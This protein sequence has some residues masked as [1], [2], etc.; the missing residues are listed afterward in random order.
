MKKIYF[1]LSTFFALPSFLLGQEIPQTQK[2]VITKIAA[3]WCP[4]CG[5]QAWDNFEAL[6]EDYGDEA[7]F[8]N[9]HPSRSS[10]LHSPNAADFS[11]NL[12]EA[13]GQPL[14]YINR[15]KYITSAILSN[16]EEA[17]QTSKELEPLANTGVTATIKNNEIEARAKVQFFQEGEGSFLLSLLLIED[18]IIANQSNRGNNV[19]HKKI[20]RAAFSEDTFGEIISEGIVAQNAQFDYTRTIA[21]SEEWN[22]DNLEVIAILWRQVDNEYEFVNANTVDASFSTSTNELENIGIK[23]A[24]SPTI[25]SETTS[26][27]LNIPDKLENAHLGVLN[28]NGQ[29]VQTIFSGNLPKGKHQFELLKDDFPIP[30]I[31]FMRLTKENHSLSK[32]FVVE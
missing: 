4:T 25:L 19:S 31:Y 10:T 28:V 30:G 29:V 8:I 22:T 27:Q 2:V 5:T 9:I 14:F 6:I 24:I 11:E 17:I 26:I 7:V 21:L 12:P 23:L 16:A 13:W 15:T 20:L 18:G 32:S 3:T 1:L